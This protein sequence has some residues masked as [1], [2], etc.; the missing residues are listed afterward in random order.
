MLDGD[1][2]TGVA[3]HCDSRAAE[4]AQVTVTRILQPP[5]VDLS[6][7]DRTVRERIRCESGE[8]HVVAPRETA[9]GERVLRL[10]RGD[11]E[12]LVCAYGDR[13]ALWL[14]PSGAGG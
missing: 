14:W 10:A 12:L 1:S 3:V 2:R 11:Y 8:L 6:G 7:C 4:S 5:E 9:F 13:Y